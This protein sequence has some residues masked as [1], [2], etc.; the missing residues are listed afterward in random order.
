MPVRRLLIPQKPPAGTSGEPQPGAS[1]LYRVSNAGFAG[2]LLA[3]ARRVGNVLFVACAGDLG[4]D[5]TIQVGEASRTDRAIR[6]PEG[7]AVSSP[8]TL[9]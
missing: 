9:S 7:A 2:Q 3:A 4:K 5:H 8:P 6:K 1:G